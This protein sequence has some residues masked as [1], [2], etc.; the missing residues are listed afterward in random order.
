[1]S[2]EQVESRAL[3]LRN[4][5]YG[6]ADAVVT[7]LTR[8]HGRVSC[9]ARGARRSTR[10]FRGGL[11]TFAVLDVT[12]LR[13]PE[14][15]STLTGTDVITSWA[16]IGADL[17]RLA[18]GSLV[19]E[20]ADLALQEGQGDEALFE[21]LTRFIAWLADVDDGAHVV[22]AGVHR[23][24]LILLDELGQFPGLGC[25]ARS[26]R[27]V[28]ELSEPALVPHVG[29]VGRDEIRAGESSWPLGR[30]GVA[31][32]DTLAQGR[33]PDADAPAVRRR[34]SRSL[35]SWWC[36]VVEREPRSLAFYEETFGAG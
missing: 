27:A 10:R 16:R 31:W 5:G 9:F 3:V 19:L 6:D 2:R 8:S 21:R 23:M 18:A 30:D 32:L 25:S 7:L 13:K 11:P 12:L 33:F 20:L 36:W 35:A 22:E 4:V 15:L 26:G 17:R 28:A 24:M 1:M 29:L 34:V 14:G